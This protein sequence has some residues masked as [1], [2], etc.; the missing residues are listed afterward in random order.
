MHPHIPEH[1]QSNGIQK[2]DVSRKIIIHSWG[3][4]HWNQKMCTCQLVSLCIGK[5]PL[6]R[7]K[8]LFTWIENHYFEITCTRHGN[9]QHRNWSPSIR[10]KLDK[11]PL[12]AVLQDPDTSRPQGSAKYSWGGRCATLK[13]SFDRPMCDESHLEYRLAEPTEWAERLWWLGIRHRQPHH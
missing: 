4:P 3:R 5:K 9:Q 8:I 1:S 11:T 10:P 6:W 7:P 13:P 12:F 2:S